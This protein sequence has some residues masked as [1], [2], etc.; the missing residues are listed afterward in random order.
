MLGLIPYDKRDRVHAIWDEIEYKIGGWT[1]G[2]MVLMLIIGTGSGIAYYF[3]ELR[4]WLALAIYMGR[5]NAYHRV[6][7]Y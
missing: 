3:L 7:R 6:P 4:F 5:R 1:R 2:Q